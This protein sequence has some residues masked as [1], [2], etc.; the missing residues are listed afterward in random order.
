MQQNE[1]T[2]CKTDN[3]YTVHSC[4]KEL[5]PSELQNNV[6]E[7]LLN[8]YLSEFFIRFWLF[9]TVLHFW[10]ICTIT[11]W[12]DISRHRKSILPF[13]LNALTSWLSRRELRIFYICLGSIIS[14]FG[15]WTFFLS[16]WDEK[17]KFKCY[18]TI[19]CNWQKKS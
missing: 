2:Y 11:K 5:L 6:G 19:L 8:E 10:F 4:Q 18:K 17:S 1:V 9:I 13:K 15:Y 3:S 7:V 12:Y 14:S 16:E